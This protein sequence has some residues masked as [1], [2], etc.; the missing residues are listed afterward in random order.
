M[1]M[2]FGNASY[3]HARTVA[4]LLAGSALLALAGCGAGVRTAAN[5]ASVPATSLTVAAPPRLG[6]AWNAQD[7]TLRAIEGIPGA[8]QF[9]ESVTTAGTFELGE[10]DPTGSSAVLLGPAQS[11]YIVALPSGSP[12]PLAAKAPTGSKIVFSPQGTYALVFAQGGVEA[13]L[14]TQF[15]SNPQVKTLSFSAPVSDAAVS[16]A[17]SV[18]TAQTPS[19]GVLVQTLGSLVSQ[20]LPPVKSLGGMSFIAGTDDLLVADATSNSL[21]R[22]RTASGG[23]TSSQIPTS[24]LLK[25]PAA[26][27]T[28]RS[29]RWA[30]L[31]NGAD[32]S[33]V[34][35]DLSGST[36]AQRTACDCQASLVRPLAVDGVFR[37]TT[38]QDGPVWIGD[39]SKASFPVLFIPALTGQAKAAR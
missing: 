7:K 35:V 38:L 13:R 11:L 32:G 18:A 26:L 17:G 39:S 28:S 5:S 21:L 19:S 9:G 10:A 22:Y 29:A 24:G 4:V 33:V 34:R 23:G 25:T 2:L 15:S 36:P 12:V 37:L 6:Y 8:A 31:T 27:A 30:V 14:L 3:S 1:C 20:T 16:D